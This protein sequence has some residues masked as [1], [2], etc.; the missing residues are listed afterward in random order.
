MEWF[1]QNIGTII[2]LVAVA[3][4][5]GFAVYSM[6]KD[7]KAGKS[8]CGSSCS[9]CPMAGKCHSASPEKEK[10]PDSNSDKK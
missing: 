9:C 7:K 2:V 6:L 8:S 3:F 5:S 4:A 10:S 1:M